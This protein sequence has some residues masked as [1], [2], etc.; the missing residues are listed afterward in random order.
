M[1]RLGRIERL[2][3]RG[4][5][6]VEVDGVLA[7]LTRAGSAA[8]A[9]S[10]EEARDR[11]HE[12]LRAVALLAAR[13]RQRVSQAGDLAGQSPSRGGR[14]RV[15]LSSAYVAATS[16]QAPSG[17]GRIFPRTAEM[18]AEMGRRPETY[19]ASGG[20]WSGVQAR[21]VGSA[22]DAFVVDFSGSSEGRGA[23]V[24]RARRG[25][26]KMLAAIRGERVRN[27][28]KAGAI[29]AQQGVH[30][31]LPAAAEVDTLADVIVAQWQAAAVDR[32]G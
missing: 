8:V 17:D 20:M 25:G 27:Q 32:L 21:A 3:R 14:R 29:F 4:I 10:S 7:R 31:L 1:A 11:I 19:S 13:I 30:V 12:R 16:M 18:Y 2:T 9:Q 28:W 5:V 23:P 15:Y 6:A 24:F 26:G 22:G